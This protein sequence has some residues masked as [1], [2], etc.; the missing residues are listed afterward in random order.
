MVGECG[1]AEV[2]QQAIAALAAPVVGAVA[3]ASDAFL[4]G[5]QGGP[6]AALLVLAQEAHQGGA[7]DLGAL[8]AGERAGLD[9]A[10]LGRPGERRL[11]VVEVAVEAF[12]PPVSEVRSLPPAP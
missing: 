10:P 12:T 9:D 1:R 5:V 3:L 11:E 4:A 7:V 6:E 2:R 8:D